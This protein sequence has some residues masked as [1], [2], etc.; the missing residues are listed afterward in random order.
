[1]RKYNAREWGGTES[2]V[3]RLCVGLRSAKT[4]SVV[5]CPRLA[6]PVV[7][8]PLAESG[9]EVKRYRGFLPIW[10]LGRQQREALLYSGGNLMSFDLLPALWREPGLSIIHTHC[11]NRI[12]AI[13]LNAARIR[14]IPLVVSIH[15][16]ALSMPEAVR[17]Q[18]REPLR[19]TFDWGR[20]F[21]VA[22]GS[23]RLLSS[24]D[25]IIVFNQTEAKLLRERYPAR[26][27]LLQPHGV[28]S[29]EFGWDC[30]HAALSAFP[31]LAGKKILL[32]AGRIDPVKNHQWV[33]KNAAGILNEFS[34]AAIVLAGSNGG[35]TETVREGICRVGLEGRVLLTGG[36]VPG[37]ARLIGLFQLARALVLPSVTETF[38]IVLLEAW[39]AGIPVIAS[40]NA[41]SVDLVEEGVNGWSFDLAK[42]EEF[43][44]A[45][46]VALG[47]PDLARRMGE[48]GRELVKAKYDSAILACQVRDLYR[49]LIEERA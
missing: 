14:G 2:A 33:I 49:Q 16:G 41:G 31:N 37:D 5:Y 4:E 34:E 8:D 13:G 24:A 47:N 30:R 15:G 6:Q 21:G 25:A 40:R 26:R 45:A 23:R 11:L 36:F 44:A 19:G 43:Q 32:M 27:V 29:D 12:G 17:D 28:S 22:L 18:L 48:S 20:I 42:P 1:M 7:E 39:A 3:K 38:G 9:I 35:A 10:G 46:R